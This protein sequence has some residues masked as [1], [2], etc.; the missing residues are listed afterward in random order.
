MQIDLT[1]GGAR[2]VGRRRGG[3]AATPTY[4]LRSRLA[5]IPIS[6]Y[7][8]QQHHSLCDEIMALNEEDRAAL[9]EAWLLGHFPPA[10]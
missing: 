2:A 5:Q 7:Q 6:P 10:P 1:D 3:A 9:Y 4:K 8:A